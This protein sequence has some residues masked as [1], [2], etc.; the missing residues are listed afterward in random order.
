MHDNIFPIFFPEQRGL[1][2]LWN[3]LIIHS[4]DEWN[5]ILNDD[6]EITKEFV[7]QQSDFLNK[8][9]DLYIVNGSFS[10]FYIHKKFID[11]IGYFDERFLGFGYE[12][13]DMIFRYFEKNNRSITNIYDVDGLHNLCIDVKD[14]NIRYYGTKYS[15]FNQEFALKIDNPK[16]VK[17]ENGIATPLFGFPVIKNL[18]DI[19]QYPHEKFYYENRNK[20]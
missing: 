20:L 4:K 1:A 14:D 17:N 19:I 10:H 9:P 13:I 18:E 3:T 12:D 7:F 6:I 15:S 5:L 8:E 11:E 16:Y 2:K